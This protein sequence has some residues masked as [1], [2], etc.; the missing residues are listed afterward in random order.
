MHR[1]RL[2]ALQD[3]QLG[4]GLDAAIIARRNE[5]ADVAGRGV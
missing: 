3:L 1:Q 5:T 2:A 4:V